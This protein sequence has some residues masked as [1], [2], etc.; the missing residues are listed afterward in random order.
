M[1]NN[2][3]ADDN[4]SKIVIWGLTM[5]GRVFAKN[6]CTRCGCKASQFEYFKIGRDEGLRCPFCKIPADRYV[7]DARSFP[8]L[9]YLT[10]DKSDVLRLYDKAVSFWYDINK[11][12]ADSLILGG[13]PFIPSEWQRSLIVQQR[14]GNLY[15]QYIKSKRDLVRVDE[16]SEEYF[17]KIEQRFNDYILPKFGNRDI[18]DFKDDSDEKAVTI[19]KD[20]E[21]WKIELLDSGKSHNYTKHIMDDLRAFLNYYLR[22]QSP[23][24]P[25]V[26][27][28]PKR[29]RQILDLNRQLQIVPGI[30]NP[31]RLPIK[32]MLET[33]ARKGE[34]RALKV[35]KIFPYHYIVIEEAMSK[36]RH[37]K[38]RKSGG[39]TKNK[40]SKELW[41]ELLTHVEGMKPDDYVFTTTKGKTLYANCLA[42]A[43]ERAWAKANR[44]EIVKYFLTRDNVLLVFKH[45]YT[46]SLVIHNYDIPSIKQNHMVVEGTT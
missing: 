23:T 41:D 42:Q 22:K 3:H 14:I 33:G 35:H 24:F 5:K 6:P 30:S 34:I 7:I 10:S 27:R 26:K 29:E 2:L 17:I 45:A 9:T 46:R 44:K 21:A 15:K 39:R 11:A 28:I 12:Y 25:T 40:L 8:K 16:I 1:T 43:W 13:K 18:N 19:F 36:N 32:R 4:S 20:L 37:R 38:S 31:F